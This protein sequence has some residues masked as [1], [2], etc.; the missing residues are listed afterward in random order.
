MTTTTVQTAVRP[1]RLDCH[2]AAGDDQCAVDELRR[3]L[4]ATPPTISPRWFYDDAGCA[5]FERITGLAEYYQTRTEEALLDARMDA[6]I[7]AVHPTEL[8]EIGSGAATKTRAILGAMARADGLHR[9]IP[10]ILQTP[11]PSPTGMMDG[12]R[13]GGDPY[14]KYIKKIPSQEHENVC[15]VHQL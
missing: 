9:Y 1:W 4:S 14:R 2:V 13:V 11:P 6:V 5:L 7:E 3:S 15:T 8:V 10:F 12:G